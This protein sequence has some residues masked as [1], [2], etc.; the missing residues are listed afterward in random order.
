MVGLG[1]EAHVMMVRTG[2]VDDQALMGVGSDLSIDNQVLRQ[3]CKL[4]LG[5]DYGLGSFCFSSLK[6]RRS[7]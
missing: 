1:L 4:Y 6:G 2:G 3:A 5:F 7:L